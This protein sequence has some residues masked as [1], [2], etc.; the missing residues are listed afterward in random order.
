[1][2]AEKYYKAVGGIDKATGEYMYSATNVNVREVAIGYTFKTKSIPFI[3]SANLS[4]IARN[5]FFIYKDAPFDPNVSLS[6][7]E[8]LQG[9]D[10]FGMPSTRSIGLNLNVTF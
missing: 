5:L 8:T 2:D 4:L 9:V 1:M 10:L 6:S 7:G 3:Q